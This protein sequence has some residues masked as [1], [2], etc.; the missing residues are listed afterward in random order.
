MSNVDIDIVKKLEQ[1][2]VKK[3]WRRTSQV[4]I[5]LDWLHDWILA[6]PIF[7]RQLQ[8]VYDIKKIDMNMSIQWEI[9]LE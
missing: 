3:Y 8:K 4:K 7:V 1:T 2:G 5:K 6:L 9:D